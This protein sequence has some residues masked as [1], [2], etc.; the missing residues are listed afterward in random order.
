[1]PADT[2]DLN[3]PW[4][5]V[6][7]AYG[8]QDDRIMMRIEVFNGSAK[9]IDQLSLRLM[10]LNFP[11]VPK[12]GTLEAG[13]FGFGFKESLTTLYQYPSIPSAADPDFGVPVVR[14][15]Y[16]TGALNFC[17]DDLECSVDVPYST[18]SP[19]KTRY[20][21]VI[22]CRDIKPRTSKTFNVSL[23]FGPPGA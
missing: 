16:G 22:T 20:P 11:S 1:K 9:P 21:F 15:D 2:V 10:E 8:K 3:Y 4:G 5:Y 12:G 17:S 14:L 19:A 6:S 13:M 18:N 7:C 23:R